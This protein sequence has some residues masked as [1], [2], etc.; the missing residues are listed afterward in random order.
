MHAQVAG[1]LDLKHDHAHAV[2]GALS[3]VWART[4]CA[5]QTPTCLPR[6]YNYLLGF[7]LNYFYNIQVFSN[8]INQNFCETLRCTI[9]SSFKTEETEMHLSFRSDVKE[10]VCGQC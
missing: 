3:I 4:F 10:C 9:N 2:T 5:W 6:L 8:V 1:A 7:F